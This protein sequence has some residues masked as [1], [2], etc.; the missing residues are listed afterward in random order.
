VQCRL[1]ENNVTCSKSLVI[2]WP[3]RRSTG[4]RAP[5]YPPFPFFSGEWGHL[6]NPCWPQPITRLLKLKVTVEQRDSK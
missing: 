5:S 3:S 6:P 4:V 1:F 2:L